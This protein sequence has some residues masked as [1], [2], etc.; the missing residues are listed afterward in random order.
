M[1]RTPRFVRRGLTSFFTF[2]FVLGML[3]FLWLKVGGVVTGLLVGSAIGLPLGKLYLY[4][5]RV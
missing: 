4:Y 3:P 1:M 2:I 5:L